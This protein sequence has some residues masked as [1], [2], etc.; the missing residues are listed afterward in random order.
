VTVH[1]D[2]AAGLG[3]QADGEIPVPGASPALNLKVVVDA[4]TAPGVLVVPRYVGMDRM[5]LRRWA[6]GLAPG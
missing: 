1:P 4:R 3:W 2:T 6:G 5:A